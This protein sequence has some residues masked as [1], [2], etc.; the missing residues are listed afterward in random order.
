MHG[1][2]SKLLNDGQKTVEHGNHKDA[3]NDLSGLSDSVA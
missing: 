2:T 1:L 3:C